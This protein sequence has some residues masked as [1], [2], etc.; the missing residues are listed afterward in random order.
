MTG[1]KT[2]QQL[3]LADLISVLEQHFGDTSTSGRLRLHGAADR[4]QLALN[5]DHLID[6]EDDSSH[7]HRAQTHQQGRETLG[8]DRRLT[9]P[10]PTR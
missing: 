3:P 6:A 9:T 5:R 10:I 2:Q 1:V 4:L 8:P 7:H